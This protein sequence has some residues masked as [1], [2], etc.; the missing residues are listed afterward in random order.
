MD[1]GS[2]F[3]TK[4]LV[5]GVVEWSEV[6]NGLPHVEIVREAMGE[7][8]LSEDGRRIR[9]LVTL[10]FTHVGRPCFEAQACVCVFDC[11]ETK[12]GGRRSPIVEISKLIM[13]EVR[14]KSEIPRI[15]ELTIELHDAVDVLIGDFRAIG[16]LKLAVGG[17]SSEGQFVI[18]RTANA[19]EISSDRE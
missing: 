19:E 13:E 18:P 12:H 1:S 14:A 9:L 11:I 15:C 7:L 16:V 10:L 3:F 4:Y 5:L 2:D 17:R 8:F 6:G